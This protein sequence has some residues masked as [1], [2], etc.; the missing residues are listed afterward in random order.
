[1]FNSE[2]FL[3]CKDRNPPINLFESPKNGPYSCNTVNLQE[4]FKF[5]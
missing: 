1:M 4:R 3:H 5:Y 2:F